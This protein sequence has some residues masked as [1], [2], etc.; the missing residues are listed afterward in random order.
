MGQ[1]LA[2]ALLAT[3]LLLAAASSIADST[4]DEPLVRAEIHPEDRLSEA[5]AAMRDGHYGVATRQLEQLLSIEPNFRLAQLL[6]AQAL[7]LRSGGRVDSPPANEDDPRLNALLAEYRNRSDELRALPASGLVP[8]LLL[9]LSDEVGNVLVVD[10]AKGRAYLIDNNGSGQYVVRNLYAGIG[11]NGYGKRSAG[12]LRTPI[13]IYRVTGWMGDD[14]LPTLYGAGALP[15]SYPNSW[16]RLQG[17]TGSGIWL[18]G[19]PTDTYVRGPRSSEGCVTFSNNDLLSLRSQ[20][21]VDSTPVILAEQLDWVPAAQLDAER[22]PLLKAIEDWRSQS[23]ITLSDLSL[24]AYPGENGLVLAQFVQN[25]AG[26]DL[27]SGARRDQYWRR[28]DD[29]AWKIVR[30]M[31]R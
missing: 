17:R 15:L 27:A 28:Q 8:S 19:V 16:D 14:Q 2:A 29:G 21:R 18:H 10:L 3:S 1:G 31:N 26:D 24:F 9:K 6:Y 23:E 7:A 25:Q 12:D 22:G 30:E 13:G 5:L 11:R 20:L 4:P